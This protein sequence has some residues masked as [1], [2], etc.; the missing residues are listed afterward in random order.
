M[1]AQRRAELNKLDSAEHRASTTSDN[2]AFLKDVSV[3]SKS[4]E[5]SL[6]VSLCTTADLILKFLKI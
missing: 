2:Q 4:T 6:L 3:L 1:S 5:I